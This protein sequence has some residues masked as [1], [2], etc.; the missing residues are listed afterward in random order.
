MRIR[1]R[2]AL[3]LMAASLS[4]GS[5]V[6]A[7]PAAHPVN[8]GYF[9]A[10]AILGYDTV[11]YFVDSRAVEG[12][13]EFT[14]KWLGVTWQFASAEHRDIFIADPIRYAPQYG[15]LCVGSMASS[16]ITS[17]IDPEAWRI[18]DGKLYLFG[19]KAVIEEYFD[20]VAEDVIRNADAAWPAV[21]ATLESN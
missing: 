11:A 12:S 9:G 8:T 4:A 21:A 20:P 2:L 13:P 5:A 7:G 18:V 6:A 10:V 14:H 19:G 3:T 15:G 1:G 16:Q 17:N